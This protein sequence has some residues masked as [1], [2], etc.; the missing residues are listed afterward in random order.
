[1]SCGHEYAVDDDGADDEHAEQC[2]QHLLRQVHCRMASVGATHLSAK[3]DAR[4]GSLQPSFESQLR[5]SFLQ[6]AILDASKAQW[7]PLHTTTS[8]PPIS[9]KKRTAFD[10]AP[11]QGRGHALFTPNT[12]TLLPSASPYLLK[13][14]AVSTQETCEHPGAHALFT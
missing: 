2:D 5:C 12:S 9:L 11:S 4:V 8:K 1:M 13:K 10:L 7:V 3:Y 6:E 14:L